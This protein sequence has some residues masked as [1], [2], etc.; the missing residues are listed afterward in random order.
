MNFRDESR[1]EFMNKEER[2]KQMLKEI[3]KEFPQDSRKEF[4]EK[5][6]KEFA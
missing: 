6:R 3:T 2:R 4:L 1:K 5:Y